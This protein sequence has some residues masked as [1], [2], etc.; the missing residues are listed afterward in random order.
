MKKQ[1]ARKV[2]TSSHSVR[3]QLMTCTTGASLKQKTETLQ[4]GLAHTHFPIQSS[5][6][7]QTGH[8]Q[9]TIWLNLHLLQ[10]TSFSLCKD[11]CE[12]LFL[13]I[14]TFKILFALRSPEEQTVD[15]LRILA[16]SKAT[17]PFQNP[18]NIPPLAPD[19]C[20]PWQKRESS[21]FYKFLILFGGRI[22][23]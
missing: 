19:L 2:V 6:K 20:L 12:Q 1:R 22:V 10:F 17:A 8:S 15:H 14:W 9:F 4:N 7:V 16:H 21:R 3:T 5:P 13:I 18:L 11:A 23:N